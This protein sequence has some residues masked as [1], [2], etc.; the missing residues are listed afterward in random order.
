MTSFT[1]FPV[2][3]LD[4][5]DDL[6]MDNTKSFWAAHKETYESA[7]AAPMK[8]LMAALEP[9]FGAGKVFRPYRDVRFAKDKTPY[10]THQGAF[11]ARAPR[12]GFYVQIS[13]PG[14]RVG[15]GFYDADSEQLAALRRA[16][17]DERRGAELERL[18]AR[19]LGKGWTLTGEKLKT[20]PRGFDT[21]HPRIELL[22]H[23]TMALGK[24]YGFEPVI[25][26][27]ELLEKVRSDWREA[28]PF[29]AWVTEN[30]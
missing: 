28:A 21:D 12:T 20:A 18:L 8:A 16:I 1:G 11:V 9:E 19:L 24:D 4:F 22:R 15:A 3:A 14:V 23:K 6:E 2:A 10:K 7:V 5:Y 13:A 17:D 30:L 27:P 26:S 29:V 25:H